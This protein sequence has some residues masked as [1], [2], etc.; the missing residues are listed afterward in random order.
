ML[1]YEVVVEVMAVV[2][3]IVVVVVLWHDLSLVDWC[4]CWSMTGGMIYDFWLTYW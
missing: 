1:E 3:V 4:I 2:V